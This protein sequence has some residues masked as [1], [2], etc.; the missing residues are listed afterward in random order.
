MVTGSEASAGAVAVA[1]E[2]NAI[3]R[4]RRQDFRFITA[5]LLQLLV[6]MH[7]AVPMH[8]ESIELREWCRRAHCRV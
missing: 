1:H 5:A 3:C 8:P 7:R 6:T 4:A 2:T